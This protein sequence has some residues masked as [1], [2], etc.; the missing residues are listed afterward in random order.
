MTTRM[1]APAPGGR[2]APV[3]HSVTLRKRWLVT[4]ARDHMRP[5]RWR[6]SGSATAGSMRARREERKGMDR[7]SP[8]ARSGEHAGGRRPAGP[9]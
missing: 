4:L 2:S 7:T 8:A 6:W 1:A 9:T 5:L 3:P